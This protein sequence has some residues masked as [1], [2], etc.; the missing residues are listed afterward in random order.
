DAFA[1]PFIYTLGMHIGPKLQNDLVSEG[2]N[3][4]AE[5]QL[6]QSINWKDNGYSLFS[7][8]SLALSSKHGFFSRLSES[9]CFTVSK[10]DFV[11]LGSY[12]ARFTGPGGSLCNLEPFNRF[13][14]CNWIQPIMLLG[15]ASFH[16]FHGGVATNVPIEQ[17]PWVSMEREY[18]EVVGE[19]TATSSARLSTWAPSAKSVPVSMIP[20]AGRKKKSRR[21]LDSCR[22]PLF[23][24]PKP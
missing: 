23:F 24:G 2:Y 7:V 1:H 22:R 17:H 5:D 4:C 10:E 15:E 11:Q 9:N 19:L 6:L 8:S 16:Q 14:S 12:D 18:I 21:S 13:N 20:L 3:Q